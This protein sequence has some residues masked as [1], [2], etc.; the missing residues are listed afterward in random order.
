MGVEGVVGELGE[1]EGVALGEGEE[2]SPVG[3]C[4]AGVCS[5]YMVE[6]GYPS[7]TEFFTDAWKQPWPNI[8]RS[9]M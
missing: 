9:L 2:P 4:F 8:L 3:L 1:G 6:G 7:D 5:P